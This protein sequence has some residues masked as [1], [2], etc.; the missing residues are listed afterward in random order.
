MKIGVKYNPYTP[1]QHNTTKLY[2]NIFLSNMK[3]TDLVLT[4]LSVKIDVKYNFHTLPTQQ[5]NNT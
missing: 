1:R 4:S 3:T 5:Q 2:I